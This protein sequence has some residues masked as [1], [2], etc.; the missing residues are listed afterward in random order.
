V[1]A[2]VPL[3]FR[4]V[5]A[6]DVGSLDINGNNQYLFDECGY[7]GVDLLPG[8]NVD[9]ACKGHELNLPDATFDCVISTEC[10]E[11]DFFY[12]KTILNM[13][14]MLKP[15]GL[16][17]FTCATTGRPEHGTR[18]TK[19]E[20]APFIGNFDDWGDY[21]KNLTENDIRQVLEI[22]E[23]FSN[24]EFSTNTESHDLYFWGIKKGLLEQRT[25]YSFQQ[26]E[27]PFLRKITQ[28]RA[29]LNDTKAQ[30]AQQQAKVQELE[31]NLKACD[32]ERQAAMHTA[33]T[34]LESKSWRLTAPLRAVSR[35]I[36][37]R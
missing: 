35:F 26:A 31:S 8:N 2:K 30:L 24:Y 16:F 18:R 36:G 7:I 9:V 33:T 1:K 34:I 25:N 27:N 14:R 12:G 23:T 3:F 37:L 5:L 15:G 28:I 6:L 22:D 20:D 13:V 19:P 11:H 10:F 4:G 21:Y 17:L 29:E 32:S